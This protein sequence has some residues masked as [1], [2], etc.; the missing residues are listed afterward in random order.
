MGDAAQEPEGG[1]APLPAPPPDLPGDDAG[2]PAIQ[3]FGVE[4]PLHGGRGV[5]FHLPGRFQIPIGPDIGGLVGVGMGFDLLGGR[6]GGGQVVETSQI[7]VAIH[8]GRVSGLHDVGRCAIHHRAFDL[9]QNHPVQGIR[10]AGAPQV[11]HC[12]ARLLHGPANLPHKSILAHPGPA[13]ENHEII[14]ILQV[15]HL[16]EKVPEPLAAVG[17]HKKIGY[18][19][20]TLA[21]KLNLIPKVCE[22]AS[23]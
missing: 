1:D 3:L 4:A 8:G 2:D 11:F 16:R 22:N 14:C 6:F 9:R 10:V 23:G 5:Q 20:H 17:A 15:H 19:S 7:H 18:L 21:S 13:L 12:R